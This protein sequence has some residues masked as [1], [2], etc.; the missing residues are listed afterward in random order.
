MAP[1][2]TK[3]LTA[4]TICAGHERFGQRTATS[5]SSRTTGEPQAGQRSGM[6]HGGRASWAATL[7]SPASSPSAGP[8]TW[9]MTSPARC[10]ITSSP[11]RMSL[12]WMSSSLC[13]VA[14]ST[15]TPPTGTGSRTAKGVSTPVRPTFTSMLCNR[16]T[17]VVG[18]NL[19]AIAQRGSWATSPRS[20]CSATSSTLT[21]TPSMS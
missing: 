4:S 19:K 7:C 8:T 11:G 20:R 12:R 21:T 2:L 17:A 14:R 18:A 9:G 16:V 13:R 15:V 6:V 10:T 1:R 5:P 3:C